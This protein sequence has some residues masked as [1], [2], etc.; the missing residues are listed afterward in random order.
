MKILLSNEKK[1]LC[2]LRIRNYILYFCIATVLF[3][4]ITKL[5]VNNFLSSITAFQTIP[6]CILLFFILFEMLFPPF[7]I[8]II[9]KN[10]SKYIKTKTLKF[11]QNIKLKKEDIVSF[12]IE[13]GDMF[14]VSQNK[15]FITVF[16]TISFTIKKKTGETIYSKKLKSIWIDKKELVKISNIN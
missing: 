10:N 15:S 9:E 3:V 4:N 8:E 2:Y 12:S 16:E 7:F 11:G 14:F 5:Y 6:V 1:F 13:R